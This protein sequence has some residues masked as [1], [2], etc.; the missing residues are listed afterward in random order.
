M[1][2][3]NV[4][5]NGQGS[6]RGRN[7]WFVPARAE[8]YTP[9]QNSDQQISVDIVSKRVSR[10]APIILWLGADDAYEFGRALMDAATTI[11]EKAIE[12]E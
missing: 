6:A 11:R 1:S 5:F 10:T 9:G 3:T 7:R 12:A 8:I 4:Q 2:F